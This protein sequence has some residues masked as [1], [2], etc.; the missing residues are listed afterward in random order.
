MRLRSHVLSPVIPPHGWRAMWLF[1]PLLLSLRLGRGGCLPSLHAGGGPRGRCCCCGL[2][3]GLWGLEPCCWWGVSLHWCPSTGAVLAALGKRGQNASSCHAWLSTFASR[4]WSIFCLARLPSCSRLPHA[5]LH[6]LLLSSNILILL[7]RFRHFLF[8]DLWP[9]NPY[10]PGKFANVRS[11]DLR[12]DRSGIGDL[13]KS[14]GRE[15]RE[16]AIF[17][18][19]IYSNI[20]ASLCEYWVIVWTGHCM[21]LRTVYILYYSHR[22]KPTTPKRRY[23][24]AKPKC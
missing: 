20:I 18:L 5:F 10:D 22:L 4:A 11:C 19:V 7:A 12:W 2:A 6:A 21:H 8:L 3:P 13:S 23:P 24:S 14:S 17:Y 9:L 15:V 1:L 16:K